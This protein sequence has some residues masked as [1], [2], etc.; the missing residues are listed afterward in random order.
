MIKDPSVPRD[1]IYKSG[2][3]HTG[4][5]E[6]PNSQSKPTPRGRRVAAKPITKG[7]LLR[8]GG[9]G[10]PVGARSRQQPQVPQSSETGPTTRSAY[11][12]PQQVTLAPAVLLV[13]GTTHSRN[14]STSS[15]AKA[16][17][18]PPPSAPKKDTYKALYA[19]TGQSNNELTIEKDEVIEV[20]Q[21]ESNG[22][23]TLLST[24]ERIS[25]PGIFKISK[26][27][28]TLLTGS[29]H[30]RVVVGQKAGRLL[31]RL[32]PIR[33]SYKGIQRSSSAAP[34]CCS[35]CSPTHLYTINVILLER[36]AL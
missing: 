14:H 25:T 29:H 27:I 28:Q 15:V 32:G 2:T 17:P 36:L 6:P 1:D 5:G 31:T 20:L 34:N 8:P 22:K 13:N 12:E 21:K 11:S 18:P 30:C 7:K 33:L 9:P 4:P 10:G 23:P 19:F 16:P 24:L 26:S 3:I 35:A